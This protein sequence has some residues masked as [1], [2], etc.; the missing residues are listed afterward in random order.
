MRNGTNK[1]EMIFETNRMLW[2]IRGFEAKDPYSTDKQYF[3]ETQRKT[4]Q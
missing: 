1:G 2:T 3:T 4:D